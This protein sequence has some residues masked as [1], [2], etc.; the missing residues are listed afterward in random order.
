MEQMP[1]YSL[2]S[3]CLTNLTCDKLIMNVVW[4]SFIHRFVH[5]TH[6]YHALKTHSTH[7]KCVDEWNMNLWM[8]KCHTSFASSNK[9]MWKI[10][11]Q[12]MILVHKMYKLWMNE[13]CTIFITKLWDVKFVMPSY[14][15]HVYNTCKIYLSKQY[16]LWFF[17]S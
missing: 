11:F 15:M 12:C 8:N 16:L 10:C 17:L 2:P 5:F 6:K 14:R 1:L 3:S 9:S 4:S 13:F 7:N